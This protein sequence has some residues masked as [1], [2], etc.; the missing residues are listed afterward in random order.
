M[1]PANRVSS[2]PGVILAEEF[3]VPLGLAQ[4]ELARALKIPLN[5]V[6]GLVRGKRG[7]T[8]ETAL[9]LSAYF[10]NTPQFW[11]NLQSNHDLTR[12]RST[13][14]KA[15]SAVRKRRRVAA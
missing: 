6:N 15:I 2:H 12:A 3:L 7:V 14:K 1:L 4:A 13:S 8:A 9:L 5:R 10:G 11:M